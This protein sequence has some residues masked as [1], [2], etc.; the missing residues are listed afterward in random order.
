LVFIPFMRVKSEPRGNSKIVF[1][2][3]FVLDKSIGIIN[4]MLFHPC[5]KFVGVYPLL[6]ITQTQHDFICL[7]RS[8]SELNI[9]FPLILSG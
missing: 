9:V 6:S 2:S 7:Y 1:N 4:G 5:A 3:K 8:I